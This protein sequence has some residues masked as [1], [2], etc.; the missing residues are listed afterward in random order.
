MLGIWPLALH[1]CDGLLGELAQWEQG[2]TWTHSYNEMVGSDLVKLQSDC[3]PHQISTTNQVT[4]FSCSTS[5]NKGPDVPTATDVRRSHMGELRVE[6]DNFLPILAVFYLCKFYSCE[7]A[8]GV[9]LR[10]LAGSCLSEGHQS[11]HFISF[12]VN[13]ALTTNLLLM[14]TMEKLQNTSDTWFCNPSL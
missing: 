10:A 5:P 14:L 11:L 13:P 7:C 4:C 1:L 6:G 12:M 2:K 8:I 3:E 9:H